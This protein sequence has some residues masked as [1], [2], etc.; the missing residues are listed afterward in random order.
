MNVDSSWYTEYRLYT[1]ILISIFSHFDFLFQ[2]INWKIFP[3]LLDLKI[4][5][6]GHVKDSSNY[7]DVLYLVEKLANVIFGHRYL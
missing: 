5:I 3:F 6:G 1:D 2:Y 7:L 4:F